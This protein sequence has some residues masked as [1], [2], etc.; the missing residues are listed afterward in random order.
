MPKGPGKYDAYLQT[1]V[2]EV[3]PAVAVLIIMGGKKGSG[4]SMKL[5]LVGD[6]S[7]EKEYAAERVGLLTTARILREYANMLEGMEPNAPTA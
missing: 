1:I 5:G 7:P 4:H 2:E 6:L 3:R